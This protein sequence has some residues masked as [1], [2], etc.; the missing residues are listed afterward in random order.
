MTTTMKRKFS[1]VVTVS[2]AV[3]IGHSENKETGPLDVNC[4][5]VVRVL[6][7]SFEVQQNHCGMLCRKTL[8]R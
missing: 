5:L 1:R 7:F 8:N 3:L 2:V 6:N 4:L